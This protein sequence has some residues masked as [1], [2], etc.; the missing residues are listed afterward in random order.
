MRV[1]KST[2]EIVV[3][4]L[5]V[6]LTYSFPFS[7]LIRFVFIIGI[8]GHIIL[9]RLSTKVSFVNTY[10]VLFLLFC[11]WGTLS[12][13]WARNSTGVTDLLFN[14]IFSVITNL[15][16]FVYIVTHSNK[17]ENVYSWLVPIMCIYTLQALLVGKFDGE[18]RFSVTGAVNQFGIVQ[19][20]I[21]LI[22]LYLF[23]E[24]KYNRFISGALTILSVVLCVLSGS[25][26][27]IANIFVFTCMV[28]IF[29][30]YDK[31]R[32]KILSKIILVLLLLAFLLYLIMN[33]QTLHSHI[34]VRIETLIEYYKG[35]VKSDYSALRRKYMKED[36]ILLF[37]E[38]P[39]FGIG[40]NN[41]KYVA[42]YD[43]YAHSNYYELLSCLGIVGFLLYYIPIIIATIF[44]IKQWKRNETGAIVPLSIF[45]CLLI[46]DYNSISYLYKGINYFVGIGAGMV[47]SKES[48]CIKKSIKTKNITERRAYKEIFEE[49]QSLSEEITAD[50]PS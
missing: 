44:S 12:I 21:Y 28:M 10:I 8:G 41:F 18:G 46:N 29:S 20:Y 22:S 37:K 16:M 47:M 6:L 38:N 32:L 13:I 45:I 36:A 40:L 35:N 7:S 30:K 26:Q 39:I 43:T 27:T 3:F 25:R 48:M 11:L 50:N 5:V 31:S 17:K 24:K 34:G 2:L 19:S 49:P 4:S 14:T 9:K 23:K 1:S 33:I 42:R 15:T